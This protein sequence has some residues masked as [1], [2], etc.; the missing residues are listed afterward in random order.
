MTNFHL[1]ILKWYRQNGR[2][3]P[4]RET[5]DPY[6]IWLSEIIL[7]QTRV[8]QGKAYY[9]KFVEHYPTVVDLANASEHDV[10]L[11]WQGL[12]YYSRARN[13]HAAAKFIASEL[14]GVFPASFD[15]ILQLKGVGTY[16]ASAISSFAF[17][18]KK[19]VVDGNV[20]RVLSR[21]FDVEES[22]DSNVGKKLFQELADQLISDKNPG[23]H[24]QAMME[25]GAL[26][27]K[28]TNPLCIECPLKDNCLSRERKTI[29]TR[30]VKVKK[31]KV[32]DRHFHYL[33]FEKEDEI[34]IEKRIEKDIWKNLFQFPLVETN[35]FKNET[36]LEEIH[37]SHTI[38]HILSHQHIHTVFHHFLGFPS[39]CNE[40]WLVINKKELSSYP[41]PRLI[42]KYLSQ[43]FG[44]N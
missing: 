12:G 2:K 28:P 36:G 24:N 7:Q 3:L 13:L 37:Q 19:A 8:E 23:E 5:N 20:Y 16:T 31:T 14:N 35:S 39:D 40:K 32:R 17:N 44:A 33:I 34:I 21:L 18:E 22:I 43:K 1:S 9:L 42:D 25:L 11:D 26:I 10:L 6:L 4:W 27:C 29:E 15:K 41:F 38:K 30:P